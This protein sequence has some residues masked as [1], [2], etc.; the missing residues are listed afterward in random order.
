MNLASRAGNWSAAHWKTATFGWIALVVAAIV[1]GSA[2]GTVQLTNSEQTTGESARAQQIYDAAGF[3]DRAGENVLV[4]SAARTISDP[5]FRREVKHV[6]HRLEALPQVESVRS[7][8][9]PANHGQ[10][11]EDGHSALVQFDI[12]G[13]S[14]TA[15]DRVQPV[16]DAVAGLQRAAPGFTVAEFGAVEKHVQSIMG[17]LKLPQSTTDH[18]RV[19]AVLTYLQGS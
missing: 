19:L 13:K 16:L 9:V 18:R 2:V 15:G 1:I 7:P 12:K 17:K 6:T 8:L 5:G 11:S 4:Q 14:D 3:R 10:V